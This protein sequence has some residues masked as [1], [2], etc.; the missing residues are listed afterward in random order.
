MCYRPFLMLINDNKKESTIDS[1]CRKLGRQH[2]IHCHLVIIVFIGFVDYFMID[3]YYESY[4]SD[5]QKLH[6]GHRTT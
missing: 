1:L 2:T 5:K 6:N 4:T 3:K